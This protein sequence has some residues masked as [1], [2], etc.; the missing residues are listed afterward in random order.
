MVDDLLEV[1]RGETG[2]GALQRQTVDLLSLVQNV[3][4]RLATVGGDHPI[5]LEVRGEI[6]TTCVDPGRIEQVL[7]NLLSNA[8]KYGYPRT[9][10]VISVEQRRDDVVVAVIDQGEG[11]A[12][13]ERA[14][15]FSRFYRTEAAPRGKVG[16]L[17][18]GL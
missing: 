13:D 4:N 3:V 10:I 11:I 12:P 16:G 1:S 15:I 2:R 18:L 7:S 6:P 9:D 14:N 17:R 8:T 5:R